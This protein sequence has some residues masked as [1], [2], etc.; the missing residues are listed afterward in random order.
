MDLVTVIVAAL[1]RGAAAAAQDGAPETVKSAHAQLRD[2]VRERL[3][4]QPGGELALAKHE[5]D[6]QAG[7][8]MLAE[9]LTQAGAGDAL[10]R[11]RGQSV[12]LLNMLGDSTGLAIRA[13]EPLVADCERVLGADHPDTLTSR[14]NLAVAYQVAGRTTEAFPL[15]QRTLADCERVLG[16]DHPST[17][18]SRSNLAQVSRAAGLT[19]AAIALYQ[20][21]LADCERV[22]GADHPS[23]LMSRSNLA[24]TYRAAGRTA[25]AIPLLERTLADCERVL[26]A[27]HLDTLM[28]RRN[29]AAAYQTAGRTAAGIA[30]YQRTLAD[31]ERVLG[32][33]H[34]DTDAVRAELAALTGKQKRRGRR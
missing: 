9:E 31:C 25:E 20:R 27:N 12:Y 30:L 24:L 23:T 29:L 19:A 33:R 32:A 7:R 15:Y 22:L 26:G 10:L 5:A 3:A 11:L 4:G 16:A 34:P 21:T 8:A 17:L 13:A 28:S 18:M 6:P 2:A 14:S 1:A